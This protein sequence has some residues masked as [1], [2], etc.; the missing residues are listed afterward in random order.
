MSLISIYQ[1]LV[2]LFGNNVTS[3][4]FNGSR[5][6]NGVGKMN[7]FTPHILKQIKSMGFTH[8]WYTGLIEHARC[9]ADDKFGIPGGNPRI[10][11]GRAGSP[12]AITDYY[13]IDPDLAVSVPNRMR[14]F[15]D[16]VK[17][18]HAAGL[19]FVIDFVPNHVARQYHSDVKPEADF[20]LHDCQ[21][22]HFSPLNDFYY[23]GELLHLPFGSG[24]NIDL[25]TTYEENPAKATGNDQ[26]SA[27]PSINDW[28]ETVKLNYG[29]DYINNQHKQFAPMPV[30]WPKMVDILLYW[31]Q[32]GVDAFRCDMAEMVPVEFWRFAIAKVKSQYPDIQF[33]AE[34]YNPN[35][36][37]DYIFTGGFDYLYD[38][39]GL[40]D[41]LRG[42]TCWGAPAYDITQTWKNL[43]GINNKMLRFLEN[44]DEQRIASRFFAGCAE[45]AIPAM[46]VTATIN[47]GALMLYFGQEVGEPAN[48][49]SGFSGDDGRTTIFDYYNVPAFQHW[50][51]GG[52]ADNALL[53]D[54][55]RRL[56]DTYVS[57]LRMATAEK[58]FTDG[59]FYDLMWANSNVDSS[60]IYAYLRHVEGEAM[61]VVVNFDA[62]S[63]RDFNIHIPN[64]AWQTMGF[65]TMG[66]VSV[67]AVFGGSLSIRQSAQSID[68][69]GLFVQMP[70]MS[71]VVYKIKEV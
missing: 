23:T 57:I 28:Y 17:R 9:T 24:T 31:A 10:V 52:K 62:C 25:Q 45:K 43:E 47:Q 35:M 41:T 7:D 11:K 53:S 32:K 48:G 51:N 50:Y 33:I 6:E 16:L 44:H 39:V 67:T 40:Y 1:V 66:E 42:I 15:A 58:C 69:T 70:P 36:Y 61:L 2:R 5:E 60:K 46:L 34:V 63:D 3:P 30:L 49:E 8:I 27:W 13:D 21:E 26:F 14:E 37:R 59:A 54:S 38:K 20:G 29:V 64:H 55:E 4:V 68:E 18:T 56:R 12:Y 71:G 22:W 19:K 65:N